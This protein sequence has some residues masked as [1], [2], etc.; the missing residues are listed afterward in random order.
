MHDIDKPIMDGI[1]G[2]MVE[3]VWR[4]R[5]RAFAVSVDLAHPIVGA[6]LRVTGRVEAHSPFD[7]VGN[8]IEFVGISARVYWFVFATE[9]DGV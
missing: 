6:N 1:N 8:A 2:R 3:V 4:V 5:I 7:D 9:C